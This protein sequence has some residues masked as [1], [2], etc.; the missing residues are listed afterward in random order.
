[1]MLAETEYRYQIE[2]GIRPFRDTLLGLFFVTIG[3]QLDVPALFRHLP[4]VI[5]LLAGLLVLKTAIIMLAARPFA[6]QWF[7]ALRTGIV[8]SPGRRVRFRA[9]RAPP[10]QPADRRGVH[11]AAAR[12]DHVQHADLAVSHPAQQAHRALPAARERAAPDR[13]RAARGREPGARAAR[14]RDPL[15]LRARRP[16]RRPRAR[17]RGIRIPRDGSRPGARAHGARRGRRRDLRRRRRRRPAEIGRPR[18]R[19]RRRRH[20]L[21]SIAL[22]SDRPG[23]APPAQRPAD[24]RARDRRLAPRGAARGR[25]DGSRAGNARGRAHA[26]LEHAAPAERAALAR[27]P[28]R[29]RDPAP[30]LQDAALGLRARRRRPDRRIGHVPRG[31]AHGRAAAGR[32]VDRP[33]PPGDQGPRRGGVG[34]GRAARRHRRPRSGPGDDA[35]A[36]ATSSSSSARPRRRSTPKRCSSPA[37]GSRCRRCRSPCR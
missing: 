27:D 26:R 20:V 37:R 19:E 34:H 35:R 1:M 6:G 25:C 5:A 23:R 28:D 2:A 14:T 11:A 15:R 13:A 12:R 3:M 31:V 32:L 16:E 33:E 4:A 9:A 36:R 21:R 29:G 30:A 8:L 17:E 7:K 22:D 10:A 18:P 24:P